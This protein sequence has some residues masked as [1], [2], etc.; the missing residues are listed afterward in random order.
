MSKDLQTESRTTSLVWEHLLAFLTAAAILLVSHHRGGGGGATVGI[1]HPPPYAQ[2]Q[3]APSRHHVHSTTT[4]TTN[5]SL[6]ATAAS[7]VPVD[8]SI[9]IL[10]GLTS[11]FPS[12]RI[13]ERTL[14]SLRY[15]EGLS[16]NTPVIISIEGLDP[17]ADQMRGKYDNILVAAENPLGDTPTN[18]RRLIEYIH[19]LTTRYQHKYSNVKVVAAPGNF[20]HLHIGGTIYQGLQHIDT[21]Y[22]YI[23]Q[24]DLPFRRN[25]NHTA[26]IGAMQRYPNVLQCIRFSTFRDAEAWDRS[27]VPL[28][29]CPDAPHHPMQLAFDEGRHQFFKN[30]WF[31][32]NPHLTTKQYYMEQVIPVGMDDN[33]YQSPEVALQDESRRN[34]TW[35]Q[36]V[37][38]SNPFHN[39]QG[40]HTTHLD[41]RNRPADDTPFDWEIPDEPLPEQLREGTGVLID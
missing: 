11:Q 10:T 16:T 33:L 38:G 29:E 26:L 7:P 35:G 37:Y 28:W 32:D 19:V 22:V 17:I 40:K 34:C 41:A 21:P 31:S 2:P 36:Y 39:F 5:H 14:R 23:I 4:I 13:I 3:S 24:H 9:L 20:T 25:V 18:R 27:L 6:R 30:I 15:L 8:T 12:I 1:F